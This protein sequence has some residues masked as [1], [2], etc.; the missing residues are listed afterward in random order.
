MNALVGAFNQE[1]AIVGAFSVIVKTDCETDGSFY[2]RKA[3][4]TVHSSY[5]TKQFVFPWNPELAH[6]PVV[7][8]PIATDPLTQKKLKVFPSAVINASKVWVKNPACNYSGV[9]VELWDPTWPGSCS[10]NACSFRS[11]W[12]INYLPRRR[13]MHFLVSLLF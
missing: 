2:S 4:T 1:K 13:T 11:R 10:M 6:K 3:G 5:A 7:S 8:Q 12:L 9:K